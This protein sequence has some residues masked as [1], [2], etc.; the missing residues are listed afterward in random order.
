MDE[1]GGRDHA[2]DG[3]GFGVPEGRR[4]DSLLVQGVE[5]LTDGQV[6]VQQ[7]HLARL[8]YELV[9]RVVREK[10][11]DAFPG[12]RWLL[13]LLSGQTQLDECPLLMWAANHHR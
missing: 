11:P 7:D 9:A 4:G 3:D 12:V 2:N 13:N 5:G 1:V 8:G 10:V 6:H